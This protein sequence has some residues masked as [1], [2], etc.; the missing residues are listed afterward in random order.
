MA[1]VADLSGPVLDWAVCKAGGGAKDIRTWIGGYWDYNM[2]HYSTDWSQGGPIIDRLI[3]EAGLI[4]RRDDATG[5]GAVASLDAPHG[6]YFGP[7]P[8]IAAMRC[9]VAS[10][11]GEE[12]EIP[13]ELLNG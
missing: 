9:Y 1:R 5:K 4:L 8:L 3:L 10:Q 7:T 2:Y 11:G 12:V 13:K 6:F